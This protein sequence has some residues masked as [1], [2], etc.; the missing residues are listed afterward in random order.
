MSGALRKMEIIKRKELY[1]DLP[2]Q[3]V[4]TSA[5]KLI[6]AKNGTSKWTLSLIILLNWLQSSLRA[7]IWS[8]H[9]KALSSVSKKIC[10]N[11]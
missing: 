5:K 11:N 2:K 6:I 8:S 10:K 3:D 9:H 7:M 4:T 1:V